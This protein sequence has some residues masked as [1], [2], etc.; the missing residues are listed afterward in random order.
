MKRE[1]YHRWFRTWM[2]SYARRYNQFNQSRFAICLLLGCLLSFP[3]LG[4]C[5]TRSYLSTEQEIN[6]GKEGA[7]QVE[8]EYRV[9]NSGPQVDRVRRIGNS[10]LSH[11]ADRRAVPYTFAVVD[12]K[13]VNAFAL[14]GGPIYTT[15]ELLAMLGN[16]NDALAGVLGHE[17]GHINARHAARQMSS[18][19]TTNILLD[20]ALRSPTNRELAGLG[21]RLVNLKYSRNDEYEADQ[22][23][24]GYAQRAGYDPN[25]IIRFF[26][27]LQQRA[28]GG[29]SPEWLST[30]PV[31]GARIARAQMQIAN[32]N[33]RFGR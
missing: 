2:S 12:S 21:A 11:M 24:I 17:L 18:Q 28:G 31:T 29:G 30:H 26:E 22:R 16:D 27:K 25:G 8:Q 3:L 13:E 14:P 4:G 20:L 15:T 33:F 32:R 23:G 7:R 10:L 6:L 19:M 5:R 9:V 1:Q